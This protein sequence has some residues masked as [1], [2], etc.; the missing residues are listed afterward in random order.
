MP[1]FHGRPSMAAL[2]IAL[3]LAGCVATGARPPVVAGEGAL[4]PGRLAI[5]TPTATFGQEESRQAVAMTFGAVLRSERPDLP[6]LS[7]AEALSTINAKGLAETYDRLY[8]A[9]RNTGLFD[10]ALLGEV[11][12]ALDAR[13][14]V[15]LK[16]QGFDQSSRGRFAFLG[17]NLLHTQSATLRLFAQIWDSGDGRIVWE[18]SIESVRKVEAIG[19]R[20]RP[21]LDA[22]VTEASVDLIRRLPLPPA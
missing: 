10:R 4:P 12:A 22:A 15:L 5:I 2:L 11:G 9:H 16:V 14:L 17:V 20:R 6:Q 8:T 7:L 1:M 3:V 13:Y 18:D 21:T 19:E